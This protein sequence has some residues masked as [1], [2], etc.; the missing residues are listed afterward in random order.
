M[1]LENIIISL[2]AFISLTIILFLLNG[3]KARF[4]LGKKQNKKKNKKYEIIEVKYLISAYSLS[5]NKLLTPKIILLTS[6]IDAFI[7]SLVFLIVMSLP[8]K[9]YWQLLV[10]FALLMGLIYSLYGILGK[11]LIKKGYKE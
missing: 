1:N 6:L 3:N 10:G 11:I 8:W 9:I 2:I 4:L 5:K 7:I